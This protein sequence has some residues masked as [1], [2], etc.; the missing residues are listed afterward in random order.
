[1]YYF[2]NETLLEIFRTIQVVILTVGGY[3]YHVIIIYSVKL[4]LSGISPKAFLR[5]EMV[6]MRV[7]DAMSLYLKYSKMMK[8]VILKVRYTVNVLKP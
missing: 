8:C 3:Y 2:T 6:E 5:A 1:M 4:R 7:S